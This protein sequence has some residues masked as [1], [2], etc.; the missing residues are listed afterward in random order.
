MN[1]KEQYDKAV[2][3][4][5]ELKRECDDEI[6]DW[7][8]DPNVFAGWFYYEVSPQVG[9]VSQ[10]EWLEQLIVDSFELK[11]SYND[12]LAI[13]VRALREERE[14]PG[15]LRK[16]IA[17]HLEGKF[18]KPTYDG[19]KKYDR[20]VRLML[21]VEEVCERTGLTPTRNDGSEP[22]SGCD[23]VGDV[24]CLSYKAVEGAYLRV[25]RDEKRWNLRR[26]PESRT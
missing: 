15:S 13:A 24:V 12:L 10:E 2:R 18:R 20:N 16:W 25:R 14:L 9:Q 3:I 1:S 21:M 17:D 6:G 4:A 26:E 8:D 19:A 7:L 22:F 11:S 23:A 5:E